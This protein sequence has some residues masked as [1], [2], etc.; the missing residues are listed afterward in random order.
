MDFTNFG[1]QSLDFIRYLTTSSTTALPCWLAIGALLLLIF[2]RASVHFVWTN[3]HLVQD[4]VLQ[5]E[6][7]AK[8]DWALKLLFI[9]LAFFPFIHFLPEWQERILTRLALIAISF[10]T[11]YVIVQA[12]DLLVF[13][14]YFTKRKDANIPSVIRVVSLSALYAIFGLVFLE[15]ALGVNLLPLIATSTILTAV[16]GL[17][18]QDTLKNVFA[19]ITLSFEKRFRQGDWITFR[20]DPNNTTTGQ[21][22]EIGWRTT[23]LKT[24]EQTF[25]VIPNSMFATNHLIN[26]SNSH[27]S[28]YMRSVEIQ[29]HYK[30]RWKNV[31]LCF[32]RQRCALMA[33]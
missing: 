27:D 9:T 1:Q 11:L 3:L 24:L 18:L 25:S 4:L 2:R 8:A 28:V 13:G 7:M 22:I 23:K 10:S 33:F 21:V 17:S 14:W 32:A 29:P 20:L 16:L 26:Y 19:G 6:F 30:L 5:K 31:F 12:I 15:F